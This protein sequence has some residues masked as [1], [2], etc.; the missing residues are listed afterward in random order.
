MLRSGKCSAIELHPQPQNKLF[1]TETTN[2]ALRRLRKKDFELDASLGYLA[3]L[4][5]QK[6]TNK[7]K[8]QLGMVAHL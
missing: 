6:K 2:R 4:C 3:I 1:K 7:Q 8:P 5:L